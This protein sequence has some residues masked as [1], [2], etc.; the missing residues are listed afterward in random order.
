LMTHEIGH[1]E[2]CSSVTNIMGI[3]QNATT[4]GGAACPSDSRVW[5]SLR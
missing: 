5:L 4:E 3:C 2:P 1:F